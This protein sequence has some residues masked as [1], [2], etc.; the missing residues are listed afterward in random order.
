MNIIQAPPFD[1]RLIKHMLFKE[2]IKIKFFH[3]AIEAC[4]DIAFFFERMEVRS[5]SNLVKSLSKKTT[6]GE[7]LKKLYLYERRREMKRDF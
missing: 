5:R 4:S 7:C 2:N 3:F 6:Y 1:K